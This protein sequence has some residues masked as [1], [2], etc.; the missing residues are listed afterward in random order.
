[1]NPQQ[2]LLAAIQ[3]LEDAAGQ[4]VHADVPDALESGLLDGLTVDALVER[5]GTVIETVSAAQFHLAID[6]GVIR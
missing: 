4:L 2:R 5:L 1:M 3:T 6:A